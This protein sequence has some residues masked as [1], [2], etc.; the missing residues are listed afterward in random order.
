MVFCRSTTKMPP[1]RG[2]NCTPS[3]FSRIAGAR[4]RCAL[5]RQVGAARNA[6][7]DK[8]R[9]RE[10]ATRSV[11]RAGDA[12]T[13]PENIEHPT[14]LRASRHSTPLSREQASNIELLPRPPSLR[15]WAFDARSRFIGVG[16]SMFPCIRARPLAQ[17]LLDTKEGPEHV[18]KREKNNAARLRLNNRS[19]SMARPVRLTLRSIFF[20][21]LLP[22]TVTVVIPYFVVFGGHI[23]RLESWTLWH[24]LSL[25][26]IIV[27]AGILFWC[28]WDF[29]VAG[30]GTLA[31][32]D[33]P[34]HLVV[35]G[36]Y[37][38]V[39]NPMSVGVVSILFGEALLFWSLSLLCY[40]IVFFIITHL[41]VVLYEEPALRRQFG[42]SYEAYRR[43]VPRWLPHAPH[44][45][46]V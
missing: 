3:A 43:S 24:Y 26:P 19:G 16:C 30:R 14:P 22:G 36:L 46:A 32:V 1:R 9:K 23:D 39:R 15:R 45:S 20:T 8:L 41:F 21:F 12:E 42:E 6:N 33:P 40:A 27:G 25:L 5:A 44:E 31:P 4:R 11:S 38:Y 28:V 17:I 34:K 29:A 35:R 18:F 7:S 10:H 13:Q 37:R 2:W